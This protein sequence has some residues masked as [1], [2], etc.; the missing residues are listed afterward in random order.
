MQQIATYLINVKKLV[1][2]HNIESENKDFVK[3]KTNKSK[4][5]IDAAPAQYYQ[6]EGP[7]D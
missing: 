6:P 7:D 1:R 5:K 3:M 4:M 2:D